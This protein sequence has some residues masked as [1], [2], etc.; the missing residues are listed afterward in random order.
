M[1]T[2]ADEFLHEE[3]DAYEEAELDRSIR[4]SLVLHQ[5]DPFSGDD[6]PGA[7]PSASSEDGD[8]PLS[9][10]VESTT[11]LAGLVERVLARLEFKVKN[12]NVRITHDDPRHGGVFELRLGEVRY[13]DES[14][15]SASAERDKTIRAIRLS[16]V[17]VYMLPLTPSRGSHQQ[18]LTSTSRSASTSST[19][20]SMS[21][22]SSQENNEMMMS[23]AVAD[24]RQS[25]ATSI[26]SGASV[27]RSAL[28][29]AP[30][31]EVVEE[32]STP[33]DTHTK[34]KRSSTATGAPKED[35]EVLLLSFGTDD[36]VLRTTTIRPTLPPVAGPIPSSGT[37]PQ[38]SAIT[39]FAQMPSIQ[40]DL[41]VGTLVSLILPSQ[42]ATILSVLQAVVHTTPTNQTRPPTDPSAILQPQLEARLSVKAIYVA[43][44]YDLSATNLSLSSVASPFWTRPASTDIHVGH[45]KLRLEDLQVVYASKGYIPKS[46]ATQRS[47]S[48]SSHPTPRRVSNARTGPG[49][50][51][52]VFSLTLGDASLFEYLAT[53]P[54]TED[55]PPG[56]SFPVLI[57]DSNL[58]KQ[59]DSTT[60]TSF[61]TSKHTAVPPSP[62]FPEFDAVDWRNSGLQRR[63]G[64]GEKVWKVRQKGRGVLKG[65]AAV[66]NDDRPVVTA[67]TELSDDAGEFFSTDHRSVRVTDWCI[68]PAAAVNTLPIH[69]FLDL[70]LVERL[71]PVLRHIS[72]ALKS[73]HAVTASPQTLKPTISG[74]PPSSAI[75]SSSYVIDDL[76]AQASSMS[77]LRVPL[78]TEAA[79]LSCPMVRLSIR[80]PAP[81]NRRGTWGDGAHLR[82]GI[83]TLDLHGLY[84][85][86][87]RV[88][89]VPMRPRGVTPRGSEGTSSTVEW[90]EMLLFFCRVSG[91][92]ING[93]P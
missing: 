39:S 49:P 76:D 1:T 57:F 11:V 70:S 71:L 81:L 41:T 86:I 10:G 62:V 47:L 53:A 40:I 79:V 63:G 16:G 20:S 5:L 22:D 83:V 12:V 60:S 18:F 66:E 75:R 25:M 30:G 42:S 55:S 45:L 2:A 61:L 88:N 6:V 50:S 37:S 68:V 64:A 35:E 26:D 82:S 17:A 32:P 7:F 36:V 38:R 44:V 80:C 19:L 72:P 29:E 24:L 48:G 59:Y 69:I 73:S 78:R 15:G 65:S 33:I 91:E 90:K 31:E 74:R 3:L 27:Y 34:R 46:G 92:F 23:L 51:P 77:T 52:P 85:R 58:L 14:G 21:T 56:G 13:A 28:S 93:V 87:G 9:P 67:R 54:S 89:S 43:M 8:Q 84:A 4:Q